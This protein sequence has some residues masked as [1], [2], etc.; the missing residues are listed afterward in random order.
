MQAAFV[1]DLAELIAVIES[2]GKG[3]KRR[4]TKVSTINEYQGDLGEVVEFS[5]IEDTNTSKDL[6]VS[7]KAVVQVE[8]NRSI[9]RLVD[10]FNKTFTDL[11]ACASD[12]RHGARNGTALSFVH[13]S[14][15]VNDVS[16]DNVEHLEW[17]GG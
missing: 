16:D 14:E 10:L 13:E 6:A 12:A 5:D 1:V 11:A 3:S 15:R 8:A 17:H 7:G 9:D 4:E 2:Q